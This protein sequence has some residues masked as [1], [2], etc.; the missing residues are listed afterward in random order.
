V[1]GVV[2]T[3]R[4]GRVLAWLGIYTS[5]DEEEGGGGM[6]CNLME[7]AKGMTHR[8]AGKVLFTRDMQYIV[9]SKSSGKSQ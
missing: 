3:S 2:Q 4:K 1:E 6:T 7:A 9:C 5:L 8:M